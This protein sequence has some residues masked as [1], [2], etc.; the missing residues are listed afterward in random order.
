MVLN[1]PHSEE[2]LMY[3]ADLHD[4][5]KINMDINFLSQTCSLDENRWKKIKKHPEIGYRIAQAIHQISTISDA[6]WAH[7]ERWDGTGY[8]R[9]LSKENIPLLARVLAIADAYDAMRCGRPYQPPLKKEEAMNELLRC[10]GSQFDPNLV[11]LFIKHCP[12]ITSEEVFMNNI[13]N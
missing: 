6:I 4:L 2:E 12:I 11:N 3:L 9:G 1:L 5:G 13:N 8:P 7:H 10:S